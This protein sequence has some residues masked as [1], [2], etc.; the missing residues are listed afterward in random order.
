MLAWL[1]VILSRILLV[2]LGLCLALVVME[3]VLR[4]GAGFVGRGL[5]E[6]TSW[7]GKWRMLCLGD[8]NTYGLYV[9]KSQA[10]PQVFE[11]LW[12]ANPAAAVGPVQV[13]NLGFPSTN[14]SKLAK[15]FRHMLW[16][17]R[18]D[19]VTVMIGVN[20]RWTVPETAAASPN[21]LDRLAAALW[22]GSRVYR[23]LYMV[24][25]AFQSRRLEVSYEPSSGIEHGH[26]TAHYGED[27]FELGWNKIPRGGVPGYQPAVELRQDLQTLAAQAAEFGTRL[28]LMT[29]AAD[30]GF[31][32]WAN[33]VIRAAAKATGTPLIDVAAAFAPACPLP[34]GAN[35]LDGPVAECPELFP[36]QHPT[37]LGHQRV[38]QILAQQVLPAL[39]QSR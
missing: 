19:I 21:R 23:F 31:Y 24:R 29:Y 12:N 33:D 37:V 11:A 18:P 1:R 10:Y 22:R 3:G 2:L 9:D 5:A 20:D 7:L 30:S 35:R 4:I 17:F 39:Q 34:A 38:A 32:A 15:D 14:S 26:G 36:D 16:M 6:H 28:V 25:Q 8:S 13:L 27:E